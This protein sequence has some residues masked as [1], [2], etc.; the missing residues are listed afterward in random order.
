MKSDI[1]DFMEWVSGKLEDLVA[2]EV[3]EQVQ[4]LAAGLLEGVKKTPQREVLPRA[5]TLD[6][7]V[8][9]AVKHVRAN[10]AAIVAELRAAVPSEREAIWTKHGISRTTAYGWMKLTRT[11][12]PKAKKLELVAEAKRVGSVTKVAKENGVGPHQLRKWSNGEALNRP[13]G[14]PG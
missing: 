3:K 2:A 7:A 12:L 6:R 14:F 9:K 10:R 8:K 11:V 1:R 13:G 4:K 5:T